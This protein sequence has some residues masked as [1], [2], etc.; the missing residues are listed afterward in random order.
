MTMLFVFALKQFLQAIF[1]SAG[2]T[3]VK[4]NCTTLLGLKS[5]NIKFKLNP[6]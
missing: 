3:S 2:G 4:W 6:C 1:L 5:V